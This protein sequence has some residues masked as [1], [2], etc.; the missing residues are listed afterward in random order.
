MIVTQAYRFALD[1]MDRQVGSLL[2]HA[3][4]TRAGH[5]HQPTTGPARESGAIVVED[6]KGHR[7]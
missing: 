4:A 5:I 7:S 2:R 6:R 1:P 3:R